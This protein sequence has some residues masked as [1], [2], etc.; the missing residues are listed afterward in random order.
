M[1]V[2]LVLVTPRLALGVSVSVSVAL[3][4]PGVGSLTVDEME[5]VLASDPVALAATLQFAVNVAVPFTGRFT[6]ALM[7]PE[8]D[9]G[10]LPPLPPAHVHVQ[11][12]NAAAK[13]SV[14]V[15]PVT[16]VGPALLA[17][18]V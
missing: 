12:G 9:A 18:M 16:P 13:L 1:P 11:P 10:Q 8:P 3:L 2:P 4:F 6:L 15:A 14:T 5:A 7:L 17:T